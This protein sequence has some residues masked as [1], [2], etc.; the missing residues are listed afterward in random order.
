MD[1]VAAPDVETNGSDAPESKT[2]TPVSVGGLTLKKRTPSRTSTTTGAAPGATPSA[3]GTAAAVLT[4]RVG[5]PRTTLRPAGPSPAKVSKRMERFSRVMPSRDPGVRMN[6]NIRVPEIRVIDS[7]GQMIGVMSP[8]EGLEIARAKMLDLIEIVPNAK[9]P[10]CKIIDFGKWKYEQQKKDK[11]AKKASHQQLLKEVRFHPRTDTHDFEF[12]VRHAR[13]FIEEGHKVKAY[14]QFKGR[15]VSY[16]QFGEKLLTDFWKRMEDIAK[17]DQNVSMMGRT[18][19]MVLSPAG[20][21]AKAGT[22]AKAELKP[23]PR[24]ELRKKEQP[25]VDLDISPDGQAEEPSDS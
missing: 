18:M 8:K 3:P 13:A 11:Q 1:T 7:E 23:E 9:P 10:V 22:E 16:K 2:P 15:E 5:P 17:I 6:E 4:P 21:K 19:S 20:K 14:V 12:K 25:S 24:A